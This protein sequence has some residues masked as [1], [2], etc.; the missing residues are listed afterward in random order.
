MGE[1]T[2]YNELPNE[3]KIVFICLM[4]AAIRMRLE[5]YSERHFLEFA[6]GIWETVEIND[7]ED[8]MDVMEDLMEHEINDKAKNLSDDFL[9]RAGLQRSSLKK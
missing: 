2:H 4:Q 1:T 8:L 3:I 7:L 5:E 6:K 9:K